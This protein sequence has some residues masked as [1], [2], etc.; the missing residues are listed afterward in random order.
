MRRVGA[1]LGGLVILAA[2]FSARALAGEKAAD[3]PTCVT[4]PVSG[5]TECLPALGLPQLP[6]PPNVPI[7][8]APQLPNPPALPQLPAPPP[9]PKLPLPP[10]PQ[11]PQLPAVPLPPLPSL[12]T[13]PTPGTTS[14]SVTSHSTGVCSLPGVG[15]QLAGQPVETAMTGALATVGACPGT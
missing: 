4:I 1:V 13:P 8:P 2:P 10:A 9:V 3:G 14:S 12:P 11:L 5:Q 15:G 7:P 6:A